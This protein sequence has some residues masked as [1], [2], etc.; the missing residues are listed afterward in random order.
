MSTIIGNLN[1]QRNSNCVVQASQLNGGNN[2]QFFNLQAMRTIKGTVTFPG[3]YG[4]SPSQGSVLVNE[5]DGGAVELGAADVI[6]AAVVENFNG[7][8]LGGAAPLTATGANPANYSVAFSYGALP[9]YNTSTS[10]WVAGAT[11]AAI[12]NALSVE[13]LNAGVRFT[14]IATATSGQ[15]KYWINCIPQE[16]TVFGNLHPMLNVTLLVLNPGLAM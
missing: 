10:S 14:P 3:S 11:G 13:S 15:M 6:V 8:P 7:S 9:T 4:P 5:Y 1:I 16:S 2:S 12:S